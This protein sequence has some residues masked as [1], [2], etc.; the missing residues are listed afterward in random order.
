MSRITR[1]PVMDEIEYPT[2]DGKPMAET[3]LHV[4]LLAALIQTLEA[5]FRADPRVYVWGNMMMYYE[6]GNPRRHVAPDIFFVRGVPKHMRE[7]YLVWR[8]RRA[9][10]VVIELT[11]RSTRR[12]DTDTKFALYRDV[13]RVREYFLFDPRAE[14]LDPPLQGYRL[15]AGQYLP[16]KPVTGR[17]PSRWLKLHLEG[18]GN[19]LRLWDPAAGQ[20]LLSPEEARDQAAAERDQAEAEVERL[21]REVE[22]LRRRLP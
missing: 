5:F 17:L 20:W 4:R 2:A 13:L 1:P 22:E 9:P 10:Q 16:I 15:R 3:Q 11:S 19:Q 21:R 7:N 14:Y 8:E 12:E 18:A 6:R